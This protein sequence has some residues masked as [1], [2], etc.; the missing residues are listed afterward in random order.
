MEQ[1]KPNV[2]VK[3]WTT[4]INRQQERQIYFYLT[5]VMLLVWVCNQMF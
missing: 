3:K 4:R 1:P 2:A 5:L